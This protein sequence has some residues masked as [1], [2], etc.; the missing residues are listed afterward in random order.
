MRR[1]REGRGENKESEEQGGCELSHSRNIYHEINK[2]SQNIIHIGSNGES[3]NTHELK[4]EAAS[5]P[6]L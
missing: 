5:S 4:N 1:K 3:A 6:C 2:L